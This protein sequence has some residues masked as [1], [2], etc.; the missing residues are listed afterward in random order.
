[1]TEGEN[2]HILVRSLMYFKLNFGM[3]SGKKKLPDNTNKVSNRDKIKHE[4]IQLIQEK[5]RK[6]KVRK[7]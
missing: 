5:A 1:M 6:E 4:N 7:M 3:L 2:R